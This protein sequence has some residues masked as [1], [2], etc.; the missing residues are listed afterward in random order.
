MKKLR[1]L[2]LH[3]Y[4][5]NAKVLCDQMSTL[6]RG[7]DH[8][9]EF[10]CVDAPSLAHGDFGWWHAI[11]D[12]S[13]P[14]AKGPG[15]GAAAARYKGWSRTQEW[16]VFLFKK[17]GPFD[18]VFGFSQGAALAALLVGLRSPDGKPTA[19]KPLIFNFAIMVGAFLANDPA[20]TSLY[21]DKASYDLPSVHIIGQSDFIVPSDYSRDVAHQFK[22]PLVLEHSGGHIIAGTPEI[23]QQVSAFLER[24][25]RRRE[26]RLVTLSQ[27]VEVPLW[28]GRAHPSMRLVFPKP[29]SSRPRPAMLIF[30]GGGYA[31]SSGSGGESAEWAA[32][33]GMV[34]IEVEY[35]TRN[36]QEYF[37]ANYA[38]AARSVRL[39][40][41]KALEWNI[42]PKRVGVMGYS[43]GGHLASLLST[44]PDTWK[45]PEDNLA[46]HISARPDV[47]VLAYPLISFVEGYTPGAFAGSVENFFGNAP[48]SEERRREFSN[49]LHV[50]ET[51]P[52][53]FIWTT[54]D[55]ALVPYT[56]AQ[57]FV[58]ACRRAHVP[59]FFKLYPHGPHGMGLS[60]NQGGNVSRW[61]EEL[62]DWLSERSF[63]SS[64]GI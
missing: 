34:G 50:D 45:A 41:E 53:V 28:P 12:E 32:E 7:L 21:D 15:V 55:D 11:R 59:V 63:I 64:K 18:G 16:I 33:H 3:G 31:Y 58:G 22:D 19:R 60:R 43:A 25:A 17:E 52:P 23:R 54:Q 30:R 27:P 1:I 2:C 29:V 49:E 14:D 5:G 36:T 9:A 38:D 37:P 61:T 46:D 10:V 6:A 26:A 39:V 4:H 47:V 24:Q 8:L 62:M 56:H 20:L 57:L 40:R 44:H 48:I 51:H 13:S 35:R 42:D